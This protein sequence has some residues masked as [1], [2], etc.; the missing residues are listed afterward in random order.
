MKKKMRIKKLPVVCAAVETG[1]MIHF[2]AAASGQDLT[3]V[4]GVAYSGGKF[5]QWWSDCPLVTDLAGLDITAQIPLMYNH[6]HDP[7]YRLGEVTAETTENQLLISGGVDATTERGRNIVE[8]GRKCAWQLSHYAEIIATELVPEGETRR[9]NGQDQ[10]GPFLHVTK[11]KLR[12]VSVV[13]LGADADT[14]LRIAASLHTQHAS[15]QGGSM[16]QKLRAFI[17]ARYGLDKNLDDTAIQ[18]HLASIN[19][20]VEAE[21]KALAAA[22]SEKTAAEAEASKRQPVAAGIGAA[23]LKPASAPAEPSPDV[24]KAA[25]QAAVQAEREREQG[26]RAALKEYPSLIDKA[27]SAEWAVDHAKE[28]AQTMKEA[29]AGLPQAT[30]NII[31]RS[32]PQITEQ[33]LEAALCFRAGISEDRILAGCSEQAVETAAKLR[34]ISLKEVVIEACHCAHISTGIT[35]DNDTIAASF[36]TT[37][38][39]GILSNVANKRMLQE[40]EAYPVI[41]RQLCSEGDLNDFKPSERFRMTDI[42]DLELV[43]MGGELPNSTLGEDN[44]VNQAATYG[45]VFWLDR[46]MIINDDMGAFLKIPRAF[47]NKAAR[48]IDKLFFRRLLEN[49]VQSDGQALFSAKHKNY[50]T[51]TNTA[52][53]LESLKAGRTLF[54]NQV[55]SAGEPIAV[56][57]KFLLV[58]TLLEPLATELTMSLQVTGGATAAPSMNV[59]SKWGLTPVASPYLENDQYPNFSSTGWYL[60]ADPGQIDT[61]EIG[62]VQGKRQPTVERGET[63]LNRLGLGFRVYFDF[64]VREQDH[65]GMAHFKGAAA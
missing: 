11:A 15:Q 45:K 61:F 17:L 44:A 1:Q 28:I 37:S 12:E 33:V 10:P 47:G 65:R 58:P 22:G 39:P 16:N 63:D 60:F 56:L 46:Q 5:R 64:G 29:V 30:G 62:Y 8:A 54:L 32:T 38:L 14:C 23:A 19:S 35:L 51:G 18:A 53:S 40:Y 55:D 6:I 2:V 52:L 13:A 25:A 57:P 48:K 26:I 27:I 42:G 24:I 21:Q 41:A 9:V 50:K 59:I 43:P 20:S 31:I 36:S 34:G 4:S 3:D 7:E 49:P